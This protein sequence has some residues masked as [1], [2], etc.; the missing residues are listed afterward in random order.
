MAVQIIK[1]KELWNTFVD[2]SPYGL[3]FHK[4]DFLNIME[5]YARARHWNVF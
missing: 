5:K 4:W 2:E 1:D 3:L